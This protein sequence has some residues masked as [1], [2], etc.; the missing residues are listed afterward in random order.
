MRPDVALHRGKGRIL[1]RLLALTPKRAGDRL[2][3]FGLAQYCGQLRALRAE[4]QEVPR[5]GIGLLDPPPR[6]DQQ[7]RDR[8][9][10][11]DR[12]GQI[13]GTFGPPLGT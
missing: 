11:H 1:H 13:D 8:Q 12:V 10:R 2:Q 5:G 7:H 3:H 6:P 4:S 9:A